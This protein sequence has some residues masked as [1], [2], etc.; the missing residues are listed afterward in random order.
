MVPFVYFMSN[1]A[2]V[3]TSL[4]CKADILL[5]RSAFSIICCLSLN[6]CSSNRLKSNSTSLANWRSAANISETITSITHVRN[7]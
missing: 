1:Y 4:N 2:D 3:L 7:N 6:C 5:S